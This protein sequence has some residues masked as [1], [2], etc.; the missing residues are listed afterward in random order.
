M[1]KVERE[2]LFKKKFLRMGTKSTRK[3]IFWCL[4]VLHIIVVLVVL[5]II[6]ILLLLRR[7]FFELFIIGLL[8]HI[9]SNGGSWN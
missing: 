5:V 1:D 6:I 8:K 2:L 9:S 4:V 3:F 7:F